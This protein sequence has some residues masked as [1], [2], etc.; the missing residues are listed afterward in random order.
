LKEAFYSFVAFSAPNPVFARTLSS[1]NLASARGS[2]LREVPTIA[3]RTKRPALFVHG[4][5]KMKFMDVIPR[6]ADAEGPRNC[7]FRLL[8][9]ESERPFVRPSLCDS[10]RQVSFRKGLLLTVR[11]WFGQ[12]FGRTGHERLDYPNQRQHR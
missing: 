4:K 7:N 10:T 3:P 12:T 2:R 8:I 11:L 5:M 1:A 6:R 9:E